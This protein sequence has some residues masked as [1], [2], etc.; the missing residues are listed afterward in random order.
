MAEQRAAQS[1]R[2]G[3]PSS[4]THTALHCGEQ[5]AGGRHCYHEEEL[6]LC[7]HVSLLSSLTARHKHLLSLELI[8]SRSQMY[9]KRIA[10]WGLYKNYK[11]L[12]KARIAHIMIAYK[13]QGRDVP[14]LAIRGR[15]AKLDRVRRFYNYAKRSPKTFL[16][17]PSTHHSCA[18]VSKGTDANRALLSLASDNPR[19]D[20]ASERKENVVLQMASGEKPP[21][22]LNPKLSIQSDISQIELILRQVYHYLN[23]HLPQE[24]FLI[25]PEGD[26]I[27]AEGFSVPVCY[28]TGEWSAEIPMMADYDTRT[29]MYACTLRDPVLSRLGA[30]ETRPAPPCMAT[31]T[32]SERLGPPSPEPAIRRPFE[33]APAVAARR[34]FR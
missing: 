22:G 16:D 28:H 30:A 2:L 4:V 3:R 5:E 17:D 32:R 33:S 13:A 10:F 7:C 11:A 23:R 21:P 25:P 34:G 18:I 14:V 24:R 15:P 9:K 8:S 12:E 6:W 20:G 1:K 26:S 27:Q 31:P 19:S 29:H